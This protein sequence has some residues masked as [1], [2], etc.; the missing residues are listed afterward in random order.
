MPDDFPSYDKR[1]DFE[2]PLAQGPQ[3]VHREEKAGLVYA[4]NKPFRTSPFCS[5]V[6]LLVKKGDHFHVADFIRRATGYESYSDTSEPRIL[7]LRPEGSVHFYF[8]E[9]LGGRKWDFDTGRFYMVLNN[10][11]RP[12]L[13][14]QNDAA[15]LSPADPYG[16]FTQSVEVS[17]VQGRPT[18]T[19]HRS[20]VKKEGA[21][22]KEE[23]SV[24]FHWNARRQRFTSR[25]AV[26]LL[27]LEPTETWTAKGLPQPPPSQP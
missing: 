27:L 15:F 11:L 26:K 3:V 5:V 1:A 24:E 14:L 19:V 4:H 12:T 25:N 13:A 2:A 8:T 20:W 7:P 10:R 6:F 21:E 18:V 16:E 22:R 17:V 23:F 9:F